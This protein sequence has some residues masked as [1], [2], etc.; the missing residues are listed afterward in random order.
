MP[1]RSDVTGER[2]ERARREFRVLEL[3]V[4]RSLLAASAARTLSAESWH[5]TFDPAYSDYFG[6]MLG[7]TQFDIPFSENP[8]L[9]YPW[10][11]KTTLMD[12]RQ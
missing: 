3:T 11:E 9:R 8:H 4:G 7:I 6:I 10:I 2:S 12:N 5:E 1:S